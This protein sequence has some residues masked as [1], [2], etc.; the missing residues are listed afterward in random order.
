MTTTSNIDNQNYQTINGLLVQ[1]CEVQGNNVYIRKCKFCGQQHLHGASGEDW[2]DSVE[3]VD[4]IRTL[5]HRTYHCAQKGNESREVEITL[6]DGTKV[7]NYQGYYLG[8]GDQQP[9]VS[10]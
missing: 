2:G 1:N 3:T 6:P 7:C 5:G 8:I 10:N 4:G 9:N